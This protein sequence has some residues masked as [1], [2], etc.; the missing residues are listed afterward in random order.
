MSILSCVGKHLGFTDI[1]AKQRLNM[2]GPFVLF[3][4][5]LNNVSPLPEIKLQR[6]QEIVTQFGTAIPNLLRE[7]VCTI[8]TTDKRNVPLRLIDW[9]VTNYAKTHEVRYRLTRNGNPAIT[10]NNDISG[11][12][13]DVYNIYVQ[14]R[15]NYKRN[16]FDPFRRANMIYFVLYVPSDKKS[17]GETDIKNKKPQVFTTTVAQLNF[18]VF[19]YRYRIL[20]YICTHIQKIEQN[21]A[22]KL[23]GAVQRREKARDCGEDFRR[24]KLS[25]DPVSTCIVFPHAC[26]Y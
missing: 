23:N 8:Y 12:P 14:W 3:N 4:L 22:G 9:F 5:H 15:R 1:E 2:C 26:V 19:L 18:F 7:M 6:L 20:D 21:H 25:K 13:V 24:Q 16:L 10:D 11:L 17:S